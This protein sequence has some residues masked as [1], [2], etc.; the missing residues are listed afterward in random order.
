MTKTEYTTVS[1]PKDLAQQIEDTI[2]TTGKYKNR[3]DFAIDVIRRHLEK[4]SRQRKKAGC[5]L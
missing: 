3:S 1:I 5:M 2:K 4:I